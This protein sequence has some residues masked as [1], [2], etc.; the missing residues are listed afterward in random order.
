M[1]TQPQ[2]YVYAHIWMNIAASNDDESAVKTLVEISNLMSAKQIVEAQ[3]VAQACFEN[4]YKN[5]K[6]HTL[7]WLLS[8]LKTR[9]TCL[10]GI[11]FFKTK[12]TEWSDH[13]CD[14]AK[15]K[16]VAEEKLHRFIQHF[17]TLWVDGKSRRQDSTEMMSIKAS[18]RC[19]DRAYHARH[20]GK[21]VLNHIEDSIPPTFTPP[22]MKAIFEANAGLIE[23]FMSE[24]LDHLGNDGPTS[25]NDL[26]VRRGVHM[27]KKNDHRV[28][29]HYLSSYSFAVGPVEQFSHTW[30]KET[31]RAGIPSIFSAPLPAIQERVVAFA[32]F[33]KGMELTQ[34]EIV[35][36]PPI[37][38]TCLIHQGKHGGIH[39]FEFR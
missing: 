18:I 12:Q 32:P 3:T 21:F 35:V 34:L 19:H 16:G 20:A 8:G 13:F 1:A 24:Y 7:S 38:P 9:T 17:S 33:I 30:T 25:I 6:L 5:C 4:N 15:C 31:R 39:E 14:H 37:E 29:L 23:T 36:A 26:Y 27:P 10:R 11:E 22:E 28:E 2:N